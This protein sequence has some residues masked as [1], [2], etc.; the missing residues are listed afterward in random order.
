LIRAGAF[1]ALLI[2]AATPL[3]AFAQ[4]PARPAQPR[5]A[6]AP[7]Q[8]AA[9]LAPRFNVGIVDMS[10]AL[11]R[12]T[13]TEALQQL[14]QLE[15]EK[16]QSAVDQ[17][18]RNLQAEENELERERGSLSAE[19]Y[20]QK[21]RELQEKVV[22]VTSEY[23]TRRRQIDEAFNNASSQIHRTLLQVIEELARERSI[24][25]I[26]RREALLYLQ[27]GEDLT[28]LVTERL[29]QR[30]PEVAVELPPPVQ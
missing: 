26:V 25:M 27:D 5:P 3:S 2:A 28:Q 4:Q 20:G 30:L 12:A 11:R 17:Q 23:R 29:N 15:R 6:P 22:R 7:E 10:V 1:V 14:V 24:T 21:R 13:A 19:V 9:P 16:Y 18:Q 8:P